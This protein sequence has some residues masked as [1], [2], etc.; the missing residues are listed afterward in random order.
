M[1]FRTKAVVA[2]LVLL[3]EVPCVGAVGLPV[4]AGLAFGAYVF[5][6]FLLLL[7]LV[8]L[9]AL[10]ALPVRLPLKPPLAVTLPGKDVFPLL[11]NIVAVRIG[12]SEKP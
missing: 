5:T 9:V 6:I 7:S 3:S 2:I 1:R 4:S 11:S 10:V 12:G 8:A